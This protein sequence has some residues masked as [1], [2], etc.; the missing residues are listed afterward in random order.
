[1]K[2]YYDYVCEPN[3]F[4]ISASKDPGTPKGIKL[5]FTIGSKVGLVLN[6]SLR[7]YTPT[8]EDINEH[9]A[10]ICKF[11][12]QTSE[13]YI[14]DRIN[15]NYVMGALNFHRSLRKVS[16]KSGKVIWIRSQT[17]S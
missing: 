14:Q 6:H 2:F 10:R 13:N 3:Q 1:M 7:T 11:I 17:R 15:E 16:T 5:S 9:V 12:T 8:E 4:R